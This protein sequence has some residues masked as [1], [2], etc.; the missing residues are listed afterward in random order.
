MSL[1]LGS[2]IGQY[3]IVAAIGAGGMG[4]VYRAKDTTLDR[5]VA[6]K[7]LPPAVAS[8]PGR[9]AR[10]DREARTLASLNHPNIAQV[11]GF[12]GGA[13]IME[14][15]EGETL[16]DRLRPGAL[17][18][19]KAI[20]YA[21]Q[22]ARGLAAAHE[23]G[24]IHRDL[25]PENVFVLRDGQVKILDFGLARQ[26]SAPAS[27]G[28][29]Q[30]ATAQAG[31][32]PGTVL[33]TVSY[34][35]PEQV[36][37]E[38]LDARTDLFSLGV[39][40]YEMLSG[41]RAFRRDTTAET[42][43]AILKDDPPELGATRSDLSPALDRIVRHS[44]E[45]NPL[46]RFQTA[47]DV[48]FALDSLSGSGSAAAVATTTRSRFAGERWAWLS[49]TALLGLVAAW[50]GVTRR[51]VPDGE[52]LVP[53]QMTLVLPTGIR[54]SPGVPPV[55]RFALSPDGRQLAFKGLG[56]DGHRGLWIQSL[57]SRVARELADTS[58][59]Q[60][61]L[62]SPDSRQVAFSM[63]SG[64]SMSQSGSSEIRRVDAT[65][66]TPVTIGPVGGAAS[67][68]SAG[69]LLV[70]SGPPA[71][72]LRQI[73]ASGGPVAE[74][75]A[76][77]DAQMFHPAFLPDGRHFLY[78]G[79]TTNPALNGIYLGSLDSTETTLVVKDAIQP[80]YANGAVIFARG[81]AVM[82]QRFDATRLTLSG[83][84]IVLAADVV[85][86]PSYGFAY[87]ISQAGTLVYET[88]LATSK[89]QLGWFRRDGTLI[90]TVSDEADY[91]NVELSR[92]GKRLAVSVMEPSVRTHDIYIVDLERGVRQ[93]LTF[94][95]SDERSMAWSADGR[96]MYF[97][98]KGL[99]LYSKASD[100]S[101]GEEP[102]L[103]NHKSK[104]LL[105]VSP[106]G[107]LL[108]YRESGE[109]TA[110]DIWVMPL[111]GE[112]TPRPLLQSRFN[113]TFASFSQDGRSIVY[114]SDESGQSEVYVMRLNES[115]AKSQLSTK[116]GTYPRW[117]RDGREIF[118]VAPDR[119]VMSVPVK[120]DG[121]GFQAGTATPLFR[122]DPPPGAMSVPY[123]VSADGQRFIVN[124]I[125]PS[126][127]PPS[128]TVLINWPARLDKQ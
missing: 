41:Q 10:F 80:G 69:V 13:L 44:L 112:R 61:P 25:K 54:I 99:E 35:S 59:A 45:K 57:T 128:L 103:A 29:T 72:R 119:M 51:S 2:R 53:Y 90:A 109:A 101:A 104:D 56:A 65:G 4:E 18:A 82:A 52:P 102:L 64:V 47:R 121:A 38:P 3:E 17:P 33:G 68:G 74:V 79:I 30:T 71:W 122:I 84:P 113:E 63:R 78:A 108:M 110:N 127:L 6:I 93:R 89:S 88:D 100:F 95:P 22:I 97:N 9:L 32:D 23:R 40:L 118:Y 8:D 26:A 98:S 125:V 12:E 106:D 75:L 14:Y 116:G 96:R 46:E 42:M 67:W 39:V 123:D 94:D 92:D 81:D 55:Y 7:V 11:Y 76:K 73:N 107:R 49:V 124:T 105:E 117:S 37:G 24:I 50:Q 5:D 15:L 91:S 62:W 60:A 28:A 20:E 48:A 43:T 114:V 34:M 36:R 111:D 115:H 58:E 120:G 27:S 126:K 77:A 31:T 83:V 16:R 70:S 19:R 1:S 66:G 87:A 85:Q 86:V 21:T